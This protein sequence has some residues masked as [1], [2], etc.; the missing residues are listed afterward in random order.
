M[1]YFLESVSQLTQPEL[2]QWAKELRAHDR[3]HRHDTRC[4][5]WCEAGVVTRCL[6]VN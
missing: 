1:Q 6:A 4:V 5:R 2:S 3:V